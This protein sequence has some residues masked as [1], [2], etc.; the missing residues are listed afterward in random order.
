MLM[1]KYDYQTCLRLPNVLKDEMT[2]ICDHYQINESDLMRRAISEFVQTHSDTNNNDNRFMFIWFRILTD[3]PRTLHWEWDIIG[4]PLVSFSLL[5]KR[6]WKRYLDESS[7]ASISVLYRMKF[8]LSQTVLTTVLH[9]TLF[10]LMLQNETS[11]S[12]SDGVCIPVVVFNG[13]VE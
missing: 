6:K 9:S 3:I 5:H 13:G 11:A 4:F 12:S 7:S 2:T 1:K 8:L 10:L